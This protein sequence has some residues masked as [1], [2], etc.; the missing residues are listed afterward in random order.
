MEER[1]TFRNWVGYRRVD[2]WLM[3][4]NFKDFFTQTLKTRLLF[5][6]HFNIYLIRKDYAKFRKGLKIALRRHRVGKYLYGYLKNYVGPRIY[7]SL[8]RVICYW[9]PYIFIG[10]ESI[11]H[12]NKHL[13]NFFR[14]LVSRIFR[15]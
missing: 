2:L 10:K 11:Y 8:K 3:K 5:I 4:E 1:E 12:A 13:R 7:W 15:R 14:S 9:F 6:W